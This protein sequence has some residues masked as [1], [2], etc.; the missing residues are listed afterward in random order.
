MDI[1]K[2]K[3]AFNSGATLDYKKRKTKLTIDMY[4]LRVLLHYSIVASINTQYL[5]PC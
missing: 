1:E 5:P 3:N 2:K 4:S